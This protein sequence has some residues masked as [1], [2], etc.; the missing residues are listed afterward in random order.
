V[1]TVS[2]DDVTRPTALSRRAVVGG[3]LA[4]V[5][6]AG[7]VACATAAP[8]SPDV[9]RR[10]DGKGVVITGGTSGIGFAAARAFVREGAGV[11]I[12]GRRVD[13][14][15]DAEATLRADGGE[16]HYIRADVRDPTQVEAFVDAAAD[17]MGR[18]DI[19]FNNAGINWFKPLHEISVDEWDEMA[20]TNT[21]G[22]FL[23]M[24]YQIPHMLRVGGGRIV[25]TASLH[26]VGTRPGGAAYA[27]AKRGLMG[28]C[29]AAAMD[30]GQQNIRVNVLS[31]GIVDTRLFRERN[32][33]AADVATSAASV[34]GMKRIGTPED[35][36]GAVLFLASEECPYLTG[37]SLLADGGIMAGI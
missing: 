14:G 26:E 2:R 5:A 19:G 15:R 29:Q 21:R 27:T 10:F 8:G 28:M 24:K 22:V 12:C 9:P 35:M 1:S 18:I 13:V 25:I 23:A 16:A 30:Y 32:R 6:L 31:P 33:T 20:E 36:A 37:T 3:G 4:T 34:D 11:A 17:R 7:T